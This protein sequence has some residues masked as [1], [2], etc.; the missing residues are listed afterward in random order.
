MGILPTSP[1]PG[2]LQSSLEAMRAAR[3]RLDEAAGRI[4]RKEGDTAENLVKLNVARLD[5]DMNLAA[6]R[7]T[8]DTQQSVLDIL[9]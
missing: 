5:H 1:A 3:K 8:L 7:T 4:A 2:A 6:L 9:L